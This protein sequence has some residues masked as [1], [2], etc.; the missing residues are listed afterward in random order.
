MSGTPGGGPLAPWPAAVLVAGVQ[1]S[2]GR[3][4]NHSRRPADVDHDRVRTEHDPGD[5]PITRESLHRDRR[6]RRRELHVRR[7]R[8][9]QSLQ[10]FE[11]RRD[12]EVWALARVLRHQPSIE[13][14][15]RQLDD[16]IALAMLEAA[17]VALAHRLCKRL[18]CG[19]HR[20]ATD[21]VE[22]TTDK[23]RSIVPDAELEPALLDGDA[24]LLCHALR[25]ERMAEPHAVVPES[26]R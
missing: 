17:I 5:V 14:R 25:I 9:R 24:L 3:T 11:G 21:R 10:R 20:R 22:P 4:R 15:E 26:P 16:R 6:D 12:L 7:S 8:S 2:A 13:R 23:N 18:E 19:A 1:R